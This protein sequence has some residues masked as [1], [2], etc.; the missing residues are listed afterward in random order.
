MI[1]FFCALHLLFSPSPPLGT[2]LLTFLLRLQRNAIVRFV[3]FPSLIL[4]CPTSPLLRSFRSSFFPDVYS[5]MRL[6]V[7]LI[8]RPDAFPAPIPTPRSTRLRF[9][10]N[11]YNKMRLY[12]LLISPLGAFCA[13][14]PVL[15]APYGSASF[16]TSATKH[17]CEFCSSPVTMSRIDECLTMLRVCFFLR[18]LISSQMSRRCSAL[19]AVSTAYD[20]NV[21]YI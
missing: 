15:Y 16:F 4:L 6:G 9:V 1:A 12:V 10:S 21:T 8:S 2:P 3:H 7:L 14:L 11:V 5:N 18:R 20:D 19:R 17:D 13:L